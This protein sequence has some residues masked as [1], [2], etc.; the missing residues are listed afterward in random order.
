MSDQKMHDNE[1]DIS[2]PLVR[3]LLSAQFPQW[4]TLPLTKVASDGTVNAIYRLGSDMCV[5]L[6]RIPEVDEQIAN[7][8]QW[9]PQLAPLLPLAIPTPL[10]KGIPQA[11]YPWHWSVYRW[12]D[13][14]N[15][16]MTPIHNLQQA[17]IDLAQ[18]LK[19]LHL[20]PTTGAPFSTRSGPL[21]SQNNDVIAAI[22]SL[23][24]MIDTKRITYIWE[25]C[26]RVPLW[27]KPPVWMH[28]DLLPANLLT[29]QDR[30]TA[31][32]DFG[33]FGIGDP[34]CDL[35]PAWSTFTAETRDI[36]RSTL[37]IDDATWIRGRGWA[38]SIGLIILPYYKQTNPGLYAVG[39]RMITEVL[40]E[41]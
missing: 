9:L 36:F 37:A 32:I 34:A 26:L 20:I 12:L 29:H 18:F 27:H 11:N 21:S 22:K 7:E 5:R 3:E 14:N 13:G 10:G 35:I 30:L 39:E 6:P 19:A 40:A 41:V 15:T 1:H 28:G 31:V 25:E 38:L 17:A 4:A 33:L 16:F 2:L 24:G 8:Q 23:Y